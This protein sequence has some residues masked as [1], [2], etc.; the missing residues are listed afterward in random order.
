MDK[1]KR[2]ELITVLSCLRDSERVS[3]RIDRDG[4]HVDLFAEASALKDLYVLNG[5]FVDCIGRASL[6]GIE[7]EVSKN[8]Q[9][10]EDPVENMDDDRI[11]F[12]DMVGMAS[13]QTADVTIGIVIDIRDGNAAI[14]Y[15]DK[16]TKRFA[17]AYKLL[18]DLRRLKI[19]YSELSEDVMNWLA[20]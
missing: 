12:G 13:S 11:R 8:V 20:N 2:P 6:E 9:S 3:L 16:F 4:K 17:V 10:D 15:Q 19:A 18:D 1:K 14:L 5:Y 7:I